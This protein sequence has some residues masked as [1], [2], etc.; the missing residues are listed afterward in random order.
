MRARPWRGGAGEHGIARLTVSGEDHFRR[1]APQ[2]DFD[3]I[4][5]EPP[6]GAFLQAT[7]EGETALRRAVTEA[8]GDAGA[9]ADLFSGC[10]T[11]ALPM[12]RRARVDA[13]EGDDAMARSLERAYRNAQGLKPLRALTRDLFRRP[14]LAKELDAY[15][16]IVIDPARAGARAQF[17]E[18]A[19]SNVPRVAA[20]SCNPVTFA[21][22][23]RLLIEGGY[24]LNWIE[25]IDQFRWS[26]HIELA[27]FFARDHIL[28]DKSAGER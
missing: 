28:S 11:F 27:S 16:A 13:F 1:A 19:E 17:R 4:A 24:T 25:V 15:D 12:A 22:D 5:V 18:I 7:L 14:L 23:A 10:G 3:G 8:I 20:I 21:R 26:P 6:P 9:V 2:I